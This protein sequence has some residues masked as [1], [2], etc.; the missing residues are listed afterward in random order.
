VTVSE[1][2]ALDGMRDVPPEVMRRCLAAPVHYK[3]REDFEQRLAR[4]F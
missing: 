3:M 2:L 4:L 1:L